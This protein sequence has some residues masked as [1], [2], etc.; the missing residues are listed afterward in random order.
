MPEGLGAISQTTLSAHIKILVI[1]NK[2]LVCSLRSVFYHVVFFLKK[3]V[4]WKW[5]K[6][7]NKYFEEKVYVC[8]LK[9]TPYLF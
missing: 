8:N 3:N 1:Y 6:F 2:S 5:L 9:Y 7:M 4:V